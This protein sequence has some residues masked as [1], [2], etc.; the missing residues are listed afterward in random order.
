MRMKESSKI[1]H[2]IL[3]FLNL[4]LILIIL[5]NHSLTYYVSDI[6]FFLVSDFFILFFSEIKVFLLYIS[7]KMY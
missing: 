7:I 1:P 2:L 5:F 6:I 4:N 3:Y